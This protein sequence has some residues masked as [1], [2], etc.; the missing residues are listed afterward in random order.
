MSRRRKPPHPPPAAPAP[1]DS[2]IAGVTPLAPKPARLLAPVPAPIRLPSCGV[3][4]NVPVFLWREREDQ[5]RAA[6]AG[7]EG[8]VAQLARGELPLYGT[9][10]LH[11]MIVV[12]AERALFRFIREVRGPARRAVV[13]VHGKGTHS[14][15]GKSVLREALAHGLTSAPLAEAVLGFATARPRDGGAGALYVLLA[16]RR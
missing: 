3:S 11:G 2:Y 10:D 16:A 12:E 6:R 13:V 15:G 4:D 1:T 8:A 5:L 7:H 9:L 14:P